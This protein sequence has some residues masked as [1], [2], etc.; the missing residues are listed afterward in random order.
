MSIS[1]PSM[2]S[3]A[4]EERYLSH[5]DL[6]DTLRASQLLATPPIRLQRGSSECGVDEDTPPL[7][8]CL[9]ASP[10]G[11]V[12]Q[13]LV[14]QLDTTPTEFFPS[15][16]TSRPQGGPF[17]RVRPTPEGSMS[18]SR[19]EPAAFLPRAAVRR[20]T[21]RCFARGDLHAG[22]SCGYRHCTPHSAPERTNQ[23]RPPSRR[24][25]ARALICQSLRK[26][27]MKTQ[28][29]LVRLP[30]ISFFHASRS[31]IGNDL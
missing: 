10:I 9:G 26:R 2:N 13:I 25:A 21:P 5:H 19:A 18:S 7:V 20:L 14:T 15:Y 24:G 11:L 8:A 23:T 16:P 30:G 29:P 4:L 3:P 12:L 1:L 31:T 17:V 22:R 28:D 27:S 6:G